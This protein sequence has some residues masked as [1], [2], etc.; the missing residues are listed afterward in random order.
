[1]SNSLVVLTDVDGVL[2]NL[3]A[4]WVAALDEKYDRDVKPK[5]IVSWDICQYFD[6]LS[7]TQV[8]SPLHKKSFWKTLEPDRYAQEV[9]PKIQEQGDRVIIVTSAHPDTV[10]YKWSWINEHFPTIS[11]RDIIIASDK[12]RIDGDILIDDA[13]QNLIGDKYAKFL[14]TANHN[15]DFNIAPYEDMCRVNNWQEIYDLI[16]AFHMADNYSEHDRQFREMSEIIKN[17]YKGN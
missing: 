7:K 3:V 16:Q 9:I 6:G 14:Y 11:F 2:E 17:Y 13:P 15:R 8:F 5:D 10:P 1:M 4:H 12:Q